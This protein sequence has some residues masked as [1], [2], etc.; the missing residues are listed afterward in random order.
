MPLTANAQYVDE[1][2]EIGQPISA[3]L[4]TSGL[5]AM[6]MIVLTEDRTS[7]AGVN[8]NIDVSHDCRNWITLKTISCG[9]KAI[10]DTSFTERNQSVFSNLMHWRFVKL[11]VSNKPNTVIRLVL[12]AR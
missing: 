10:Y 5:A 6:S 12:S 8:Y 9:D 4:R 7:L 3:T 11:W 2:S 1:I